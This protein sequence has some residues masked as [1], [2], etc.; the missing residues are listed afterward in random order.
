MVPAEDENQAAAPVALAMRPSTAVTSDRSG[1][2]TRAPD[3]PIGVEERR[4]SGTGAS[5]SRNP[6]NAVESFRGFRRASLE[7]TTDAEEP[8]EPSVTMEN[9]LDRGPMPSSAVDSLRASRRGSLDYDTAESGPG[10]PTLTAVESTLDQVALATAAIKSLREQRRNSLSIE[11]AHDIPDR[12]IPTNIYAAP[13]QSPVPYNTST[14][15]GNVQ[16]QLPDR[17]DPI[18]PSM[19]SALATPSR[20]SSRFSDANVNLSNVERLRTSLGRRRSVDVHSAHLPETPRLRRSILG[21]EEDNESFAQKMAEMG[22]S[23]QASS[24]RTPLRSIVSN[25]NS[26]SKRNKESI[27]FSSKTNTPMESRSRMSS[28]LAKLDDDDLD[29]GNEEVEDLG[30]Q[31]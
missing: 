1:K 19:S 3:R 20:K 8:T 12:S 26:V 16:T 27:R 29:L 4:V 15:M 22:V 2:A 24:E 18:V 11:E 5:R 23:N 9:A 30:H 14:G 31:W 10:T 25:Q 21:T 13:T 6:S 7:S 28:R 17:S